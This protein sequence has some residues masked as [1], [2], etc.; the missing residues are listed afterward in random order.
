M[1]IEDINSRIDKLE[2]RLRVEME[3]MKIRNDKIMKMVRRVTE[4]DQNDYGLKGEKRKSISKHNLN[5][6]ESL[7]LKRLKSK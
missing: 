2:N 1:I 4:A 3:A 6:K 5:R 7:N